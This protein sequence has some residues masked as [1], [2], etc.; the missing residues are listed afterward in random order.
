M[1]HSAVLE[2]K[3][4]ELKDELS[5]LITETDDV[6]EQIGREMREIEPDEV[7]VDQLQQDRES[8]GRKEERVKIRL[9][10]TEELM[11]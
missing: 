8:L 1:S 4:T 10:A 3:I 5:N 7:K 11:N 9:Q 6:Q 2:T